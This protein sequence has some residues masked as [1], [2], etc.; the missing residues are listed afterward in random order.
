MNATSFGSELPPCHLCG[1]D[2]RYF[3]SFSQLGGVTSDCQPWQGLTQ[4][5]VCKSCGAVQKALTKGWYEEVSQIYAAYSNYSQAEGNEQLSFNAKTG[6]NSSRSSSIIYWLKNQTSIPES[7][8]LL[9]IGCGN[10]SFLREFQKTFPRWQMIG[11]ELDDRNRQTVES[12]PGVLTLHTSPLTELNQRFDLI[13]M[14]HALEHIPN[15][16]EFLSG[17]KDLLTPSGR[18][19]VEV[20]DLST[21]PFDILI[22]DHCTHYSHELL[23]G[24]MELAGFKIVISDVDCVPKELT[25]IAEV[26]TNAMICSKFIDQAHKDSNVVQSHIQWLNEILNQANYSEGD[27]GIF[28]TSISATWLAHKL[29]GRVTFFVDEDE[30]RVGNSH[31]GLPILS[32]ENAPSSIPILMPLR[33]D[34]ATMINNRLGLRLNLILPPE[35]LLP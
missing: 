27:I 1:G 33:R 12:I 6:A 16:I 25:L 24:V 11:A 2:L 3:R 8:F 7:G 10:G 13:V 32:T 5:A 21:S 26:S 17:L 18:L 28:G 9:D 23:L 4:L 35:K 19:L 30:S 29:Q 31:L 14:V 20:P 22:V 34:I 15:P